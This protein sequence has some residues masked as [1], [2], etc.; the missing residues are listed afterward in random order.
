MSLDAQAEDSLDHIE[1]R[2]VITINEL[3]R[4]RNLPDLPWGDGRPERGE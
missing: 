2:G 3:R 1:D 4:H